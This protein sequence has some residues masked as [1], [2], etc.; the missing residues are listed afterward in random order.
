MKKLNYYLDLPWNIKIRHI[1]SES[2]DY[3]FGQVQEIPEVRADGK[4]VEECYN[5]VLEILK[6][7]LE[8][9][10]DDKVKVP[11]PIDKSYSGKFNLRLPKSLHKKLAEEAEEEGVSF[12]QLILYKLSL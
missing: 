3:Y 1:K 2:D 5:L 8:V 11:E 6:S 12:N 4:T 9:M 10:I 7:N